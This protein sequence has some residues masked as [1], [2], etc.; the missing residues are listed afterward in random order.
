[1]Q[2]ATYTY[3]R[4]RLIT[5]THTGT[6]YLPRKEIYYLR[7]A[8][9]ERRGSVTTVGRYRTRFTGYDAAICHWHTAKSRH[10]SPSRCRA[11]LNKKGPASTLL[12]VVIAPTEKSAL[13]TRA[14][15]GASR[16]VSG[17][18]S[19]FQRRANDLQTRRCC[20]TLLCDAAPR[21]LPSVQT[22][23]RCAFSMRACHASRQALQLD[24]VGAE[25]TVDEVHAEHGHGARGSLYSSQ[26]CS[27]HHAQ[28]RTLERLE[29]CIRFTELC[30]KD[31]ETCSYATVCDVSLHRPVRMVRGTRCRAT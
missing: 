1:M 8:V 17:D 27:E 6:G 26:F 13:P 4:F 16:I 12:K 30:G 28:Q 5:P 3:S 19:A 9:K 2:Q 7:L 18:F 21:A 23:R 25:L 10:L 22:P 29:T 24:T 15:V 11:F 20:S 14:C 31:V